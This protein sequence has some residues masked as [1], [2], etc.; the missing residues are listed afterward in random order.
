MLP[1]ALAVTA[2]AAFWLSLFATFTW[3]FGFRLPPREHTDEQQQDER[4]PE[5][6]P[7]AA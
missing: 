1:H 4:E 6:V 2:L 3:Y 5:D 7:L